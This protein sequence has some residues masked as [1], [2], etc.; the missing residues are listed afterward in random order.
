MKNTMSLFHHDKLIRIMSLFEQ[1]ISYIPSFSR[2]FKSVDAGLFA[3]SFLYRESSAEI[4]DW[5]KTTEDEIE[6]RT[7]LSKKEQHNA[8]RKLVRV[9]VLTEVEQDNWVRLKFNWSKV[10]ELLCKE[11][12]DNSGS[13]FH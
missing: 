4:P 12:D 3:S 1:P 5:F 13:L 8:R 6:Q 7:G 2:A 9:G 10:N 11:S